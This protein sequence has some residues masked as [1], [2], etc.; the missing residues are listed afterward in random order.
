MVFSPYLGVPT[1]HLLPP[2]NSILPVGIHEIPDK[3]IESWLEYYARQRQQRQLAI[4]PA[5]HTAHVD[6]RVPGELAKLELLAARHRDRADTVHGQGGVFVAPSD[7]HL[8]P[9]AV[10]EVVTDRDDL[11]PATEI[12]SQSE[13]ALDQFDL[14]EVVSATVVRV[15]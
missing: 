6:I 7:L 13:S 4:V 11:R 14:E 2:G 1:L 12:V 10:A 15:E 3:S 8:M 5:R 9:V